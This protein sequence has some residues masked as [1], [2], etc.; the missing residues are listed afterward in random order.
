MSEWKRVNAARGMSVTAESQQPTAISGSMPSTIEKLENTA[1][2]DVNVHIPFSTVDGL[3]K[4]S[5]DALDITNLDEL[6]GKS[7]RALAKGPE[8][9]QRRDNCV[10][11]RLRRIA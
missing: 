2:I 11:L 3:Q 1:P 5:D 6:S 4:A 10:S 7:P 9:T 8:I